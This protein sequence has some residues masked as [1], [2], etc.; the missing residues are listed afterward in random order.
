MNKSFSTFPLN[1]VIFIKTYQFIHIIVFCLDVKNADARMCDRMI[2][3]GKTFYQFECV[4]KIFSKTRLHSCNAQQ[5]LF[6]LSKKYIFPRFVLHP[7]A[8]RC[9]QF[10]ET[11][12]GVFLFQVKNS[13][14]NLVSIRL[15]RKHCTRLLDLVK[16]WQ[17]NLCSRVTNKSI[18]SEIS[19]AKCL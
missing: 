9:C 11:E 1:G 8:C 4:F 19:T 15:V 12:A 5:W 7:S 17:A 3:F 2:K 6:P 18:R 13:T 10:V 16:I 14:K